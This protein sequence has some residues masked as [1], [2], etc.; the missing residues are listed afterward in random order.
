MKL[1]IPIF[2]FVTFSLNAQITFESTKQEVNA[3]AD[4][5]VVQADFSFSNLGNKTE[6]I[7]RY[8][9]T[10]S[11]M[12]VQINDNSKLTYAPN[13]KGSLRATFNLE[14]FSGEVDKTVLIWMKGDGENSPSHQLTVHVRI[15]VLVVIE[16]KT[17]E[18]KSGEVLTKKIIKVKMNHTEPIH[19]LS[20]KMGNPAFLTTLRTV[21][22][23]SE[24]DIEVTPVQKGD[25][26]P[27]LGVMHLETDC[28]I[29]KQK[30]QMAFTIVRQVVAISEPPVILGP[31][32]QAPPEKI[33]K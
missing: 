11:C 21:T 8:E 25:E 7:V 5:T 16:P 9:S 6:E 26:Q 24:Y 18:W 19:L 28:K 13:E 22:E 32:P 4:A 15:P 3:A 33:S 1:F 20:V 10:C 30:Q 23:G 2:A 14:N 27:G 17:L 12:S 29:E 31:A